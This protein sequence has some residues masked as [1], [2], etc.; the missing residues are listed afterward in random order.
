MF[1]QRIFIGHEG[2]ATICCPQCRKQR[3]VSALNLLARHTLKVRCA[4]KSIFGIQLEFREKCRKE[5]NF[6]GFV[7]KIHENERWGR[8]LW[9][10]TETNPQSVNCRIKN[11]SVLGIGLSTFSKH[12]IKEG[13]HVKIEF[14]LDTPASPKMVK[15]ATAVWVTDTQIGCEFDEIDKHDAKLGFYVL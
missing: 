3:D 11:I 10:S 2:T 14:A 8:V 12:N 13:D 7:E 4:C 6:E 1:M 15:K 9:Q 5:T